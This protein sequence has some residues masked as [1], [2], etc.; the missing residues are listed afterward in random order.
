MTWAVV[1][2]AGRGL[3]FGGDVPK[4][5]LPLAG[6]P[7]LEHSLRALRAPR[8]L[9]RLAQSGNAKVAELAEAALAQSERVYSYG[10]PVRAESEYDL[11]V[12]PNDPAL[13]RL[14][15]DHLKGNPWQCQE[16]CVALDLGPAEGGGRR[17][18]LVQA[19]PPLPPPHA[20]AP[21]CSRATR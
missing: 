5:Y 16:R 20:R 19:L 4:Q 12:Q 10:A 2:A 7:L 13:R 15:L 11:R 1:P 18:A 9:R 8:A 14:V 21:R 6:R 17:V 3:R